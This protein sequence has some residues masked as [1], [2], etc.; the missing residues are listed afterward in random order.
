MPKDGIGKL[1]PRYSFA[2]NPYSD[3]RF[4]RCPKCHRL[5]NPRKFALLIHI[6]GGDL[7]ILG[8]TCQYCP[9]CELIIAH[10]NEL[11][12]ELARSFSKS[13]P[14]IL[15]NPYLVIG[16]VELKAWREGLQRTLPLNH[17][18]GRTSEFKRVLKLS[19]GCNTTSTDRR[20]NGWNKSPL[21]GHGQRRKR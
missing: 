11:E 17:F 15:G 12:A 6:E 19:V 7:T 10:Q 8:K 3:V 20:C 4:T 13:G 14:E 21:R 16:T 5:M 1:A 9:A 2:L 18:R